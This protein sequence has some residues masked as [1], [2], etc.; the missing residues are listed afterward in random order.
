MQ[1][2]R[3]F[4]THVWRR[5]APGVLADAEPETGEENVARPTIKRV[6]EDARR[7]APPDVGF[8]PAFTKARLCIYFAPVISLAT[9]SPEISDGGT[10]GPGTV[11]CPAKNRFGTFLHCTRGLKNAV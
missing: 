9:I 2:K 8:E 7:E 3:G 1:S 11:I 6:R 10:P 4:K 5:F